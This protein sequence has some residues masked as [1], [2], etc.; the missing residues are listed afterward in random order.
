MSN[1][2]PLPP[3]A[4]LDAPRG[5]PGDW[6][7]PADLHIDREA[8]DQ[9][10]ASLRL[11]PDLVAALL[12]EREL[13]LR[14]LAEAG[15]QSSGAQALLDLTAAV[16]DAP[17]LGPGNLFFGYV[18]EL[19]LGGPEPADSSVGRSLMLPLRLHEP[20]RRS[21]LVV[22]PGD[23]EQARAWE[24]AAASAGLQ[25]REWALRAALLAR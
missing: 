5:R 17:A 13:A 20:V 23:A 19:R 15:L 2:L 10:A 9:A 1:L 8:L 11:E 22:D 14:D 4:I 6:S 3:T 24:M 25:M 12:V 7:E 18:R 21:G 16:A